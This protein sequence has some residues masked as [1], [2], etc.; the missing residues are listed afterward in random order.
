MHLLGRDPRRILQRIERADSLTQENIHR[1]AAKK[2]FPVERH[3]IV[4]LMPE[5][6]MTK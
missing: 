1:R 2:Y 6:P 5:A 3:T 4:T